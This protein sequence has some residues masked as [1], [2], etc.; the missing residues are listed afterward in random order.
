MQKVEDQFLSL[1][2]YIAEQEHNKIRMRQREE[3]NIAQRKGG[4][5][6]MTVRRDYEG[7]S[8]GCKTMAKW[9]A[10]HKR[11]DS[12]EKSTLLTGEQYETMA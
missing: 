8:R 4:A 7:I 11:D 5:V 6:R 1:L 3:I 10:Y 12:L 9:R 2:S